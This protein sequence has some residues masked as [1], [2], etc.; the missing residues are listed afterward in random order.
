[1]GFVWIGDDEMVCANC[2]HYCQHYTEIAIRCFRPTNCGHCV[3]PRMK[4]RRPGHPACEH[5]EERKC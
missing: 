3:Y 1:M 4:D 5:W 2:G